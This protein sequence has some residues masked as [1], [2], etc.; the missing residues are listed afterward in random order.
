MTEKMSRQEEHEFYADPEH[1]TPQGPP[2]RRGKLTE[3]VPVRFPP[4]LLD[5]VRRRAGDDAPGLRA[6]PVRAGRVPVRWCW[7][8]S[9]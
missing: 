6:H 3:M 7:S 8:G 4:E 1:Q 5:E 2:R 9:G